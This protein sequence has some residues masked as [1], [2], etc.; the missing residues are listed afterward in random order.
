MQTTQKEVILSEI[1]NE[2]VEKL[3]NDLRVFFPQEIQNIIKKTIE[4]Q[5]ESLLAAIKLE[6]EKIESSNYL[7]K[8]YETLINFNN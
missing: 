6:K 7:I 4:I 8:H 1:A 2:F 5:K 3:N